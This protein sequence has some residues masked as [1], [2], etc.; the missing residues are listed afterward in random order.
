MSLSQ[1]IVL[2]VFKTT[3]QLYFSTNFL[4]LDSKSLKTVSSSTPNNLAASNG[5]G[6]IIE[7]LGNSIDNSDKIFNPI[8][9][10]NG[11][12][13]NNDAPELKNYLERAKA[14]KYKKE[15]D[16][17]KAEAEEKGIYIKDNS[18]FIATA[19]RQCVNARIQGGAATMTKKAM[20]SI[21]NDKEMQELGFKLLIAVHDELIGECPEVNKDAVAERLSYLMKT[22]VPE[23]SVPFKCDAE[24]EDHW[25]ANEYSN[26]ISKEYKDL[27]KDNDPD[28]AFKT[29][30]YN[31]IEQ[32]EDYLRGIVNG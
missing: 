16:Q 8:L 30:C 6:V 3:T 7:F 32:P 10:C 24:I 27:L 25:Y 17:L 14:C 11:K 20:I 4:A 31:H 13:I 28:K 2:W 21:A 15:L 1:I 9:G 12:F 22:A 5:C 26:M 23:L 29:L 18:G 19:E